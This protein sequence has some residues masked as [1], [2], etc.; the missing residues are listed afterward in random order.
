MEAL[1]AG[2]L[3]GVAVGLW[4]RYRDGRLGGSTYGTKRPRDHFMFAGVLG[5]AVLLALATKQWVVGTLG[6]V[7][8]AGALVAGARAGRARS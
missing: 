6:V 7:V 1:I 5:V 2:A 3:S 8:A 4:F